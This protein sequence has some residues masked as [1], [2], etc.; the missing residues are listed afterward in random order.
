[1]AVDLPYDWDNYRS[2]FRPSPAY[3]AQEQALAAQVGSALL[4]LAPKPASKSASGP[5][6]PSS[7]PATLR[8]PAPIRVLE[9]GPGFGRITSLVLAVAADLDLDLDLDR[10]SYSALDV[11]QAALDLSQATA[12]G[13]NPAFRFDRT[14]VADL[15][16]PVGPSQSHQSP[17]LPASP[18]VAFDLVLAIEVLL[19]IP[20]TEVQQTTGSG[21]GS[22][23]GCPVQQ[24]IITEGCPV[25]QAISN[26]LSAVKPTG[27]LITCDWTEPLPLRPDGSPAPIRN[28]NYRHDYALLFSTSTP[29]GRIIKAKQVG[30]QT[31]Y[32]V[33]P[34]QPQQPQQPR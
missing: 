25:Q 7:G 14:W 30:L 8:G 4:A 2:D 29:Q 21:S 15:S 12:Q 28:Q 19:H 18:A 24:A 31:I 6:E 27:T 3:V 26:L 23:S 32:V 13:A 10:L 9:V 5:S 20:P 11:S 1:V 17:W 22:G 33:K 34:Q 16:D